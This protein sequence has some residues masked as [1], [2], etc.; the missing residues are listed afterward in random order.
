MREDQV[1]DADEKGALWAVAGAV[2]CGV[3]FF[4]AYI[5]GA[6]GGIVSGPAVLFGLIC[7]IVALG[8]SF[9]GK[10][11]RVRIFVWACALLCVACLAVTSQLPT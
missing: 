11:W 6:F 5:L 3:G 10:S 7:E 4:F 9:V 1:L 2:L 8:Y